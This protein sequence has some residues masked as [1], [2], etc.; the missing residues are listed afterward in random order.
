VLKFSNSYILT[1]YFETTVNSD[2]GTVELLPFGHSRHYPLSFV[3]S[4]K[5]VIKGELNFYNSILHKNFNTKNYISPEKCSIELNKLEDNL[6]I[7]NCLDNCFGHSLLKLFY[8][9]SYLEKTKVKQDYLLIIPKA[10]RHFLKKQVGVNL[11]VV[12][13]TFSQLE[14]CFVLNSEIEK[15]SSL[16]S[17]VFLEGAETYDEFDTKLLSENLNLFNKPREVTQKKNKIVFY[18]RSDYYRMW[19]GR[20]QSSHIVTLFLF[21]RSFFGKDVQFCVLGDMDK[22]KFP[23]WIL[24]ERISKFSNEVDF[25]YNLIFDETIICIGLNGSHMLFPSLFSECTVHLHPSH[26]YK[27]MA[28]DIIIKKNSNEMLAAYNHLYYFG[29]Y[30]CSDLKPHKLGSLLVIHFLGLIE[31]KY[32]FNEKENISQSDWIN[33]YYPFLKSSKI[34]DYRTIFNLKESNKNRIKYYIDKFF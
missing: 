3:I 15:V 1:S 13:Y 30:N 10:L 21:L 12:N 14:E 34:I 19:N 23:S 20:K 29:N 25:K 22:F 32:K 31:K 33:K 28:E 6:I 9:I 11:L 8:A 4:D 18:Y 7:F 27:N 17:E 16:Y 26:K 5:R 2:I 24:D